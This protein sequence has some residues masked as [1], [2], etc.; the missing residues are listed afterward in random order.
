MI[1]IPEGQV[2]GRSAFKVSVR[3]DEKRDEGGIG[4]IRGREQ[5]AVRETE[6]LT[7]ICTGTA[8]GDD[9]DLAR[10]QTEPWPYNWKVYFSTQGAGGRV[11]WIQKGVRERQKN[12]K[13]EIRRESGRN[14]CPTRET[15][16][17]IRLYSD[18][19]SNYKFALT[20]IFIQSPD[21]N[22][23]WEKSTPKSRG[24]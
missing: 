19:I 21:P 15:E 8:T 10:L 16:Q 5:C 6:G 2:E 7:Y 13:Y 17:G 20:K 18:T 12:I 9:S 14:Q 3:K 22:L 23:K 4:S 11:I 24:E 1:E